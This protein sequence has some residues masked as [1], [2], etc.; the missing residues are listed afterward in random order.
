MSRVKDVN[1][2]LTRAGKSLDLLST[3]HCTQHGKGIFIVGNSK[4][5]V[6]NNQFI[7]V[8]SAHPV[9]YVFYLLFAGFSTLSTW[10]IITS[11]K[12]GLN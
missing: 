10:P 8:G 2:L 3:G 7:Q 5:S 1:N 11:E 4:L 12:K 9:T 6:Y